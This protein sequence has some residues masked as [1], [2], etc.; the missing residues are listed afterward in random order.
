MKQ[1]PPGPRS[2]I[3][4]ALSYAFLRDPCGFFLRMHQD[5]GDVAYC[6]LGPCDV[7]LLSHPDLI[8]DVLITHSESFTR[9]APFRAALRP[10]GQSVIMAEGGTH[11]RQ[12]RLVMPAFS[13]SHLLAY[14][15]IMA[16]EANRFCEGC[17]DGQMMDIHAEMMRVAAKIA[18]RSLF[19]SDVATEVDEITKA[20]NSLSRDGAHYSFFGFLPFGDALRNLP[21]PGLRRL[22][23]S[24]S[25]LHEIIYRFINSRQGSDQDRSDLLS[26]LLRARDPEQAGNGLSDLQVRDECM[27]FFLAGGENVPNVI[28]WTLHL[29]TQHP[30][31]LRKLQAEVDDVLSGRLPSSSDLSRLGY[32]DMVVAESLRLYPPIWCLG[33]QAVQ[34]YKAADYSISPGSVVVCSQWVVHHDP[35]YY[36]EPC[37]FDPER[38]APEV[39]AL[40]PKFAFFPFGAGP[41]QCIGDGFANMEIMLL[42]ATLLQ[43]WEFELSPG[44]NVVPTITLTLRPKNGVKIYLRSRKAAFQAVSTAHHVA[45]G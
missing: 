9:I 19:G 45:A 7:Y 29:L 2:K 5:H 38:W 21:L 28:A 35:R 17:Q 41:R 1:V 34:E 24:E 23:H 33:R 14:S 6:R 4:G 20:V 42:L 39:S 32:M 31:I 10:L 3:P 26:F 13:H 25:R 30:K 15:E 12:R 36:P 18:A 37:S 8:K 16:E 43:R 44:Q 22:R 11:F 27:G 40:R